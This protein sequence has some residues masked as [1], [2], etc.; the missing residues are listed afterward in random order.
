M[1]M[2]TAIYGNIFKGDD[3]MLSE[4][5][6]KEMLT[7]EVTVMKRFSGSHNNAAVVATSCCVDKIRM[8]AKILEIPED[9]LCEMCK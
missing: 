4:K 5:H 9:E 1:K 6:I 7:R 8:L 2:M 3:N